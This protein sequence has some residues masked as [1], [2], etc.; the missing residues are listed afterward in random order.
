MMHL[1]GPSG[2]IDHTTNYSFL[3]PIS[4][5][6]LGLYCSGLSTDTKHDIHVTGGEEQD[7][8]TDFQQQSE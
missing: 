5:D 7:S 4:E 8:H 1:V 6:C 3:T 2:A